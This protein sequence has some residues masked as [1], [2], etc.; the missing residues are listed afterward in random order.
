M[1]TTA[2]IRRA[3]RYPDGRFD[4]LT[5]GQ[6]R[7]RL[8]AVDT[9]LRALP[10]RPGALPGRADRPRQEAAAPGR[11]GRAALPR[12]PRAAPARSAT[13]DGPEIEIELEIE[14]DEDDD[15]TTRRRCDAVAGRSDDLDLAHGGTD[16]VSPSRPGAAGPTRLLLDRGH[17][18]AARRD[19][20]SGPV[21]GRASRAAPGGGATPHR[22]RRPDGPVLR[23]HGAHPGRPGRARRCSKR[24]TR[25]ARLRGLDRLLARESW[26][27]RQGLR[28]I[29][30]D[31]AQQQRRG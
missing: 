16:A 27:L 28:P 25:V 18:S 9:R 30:I 21:T 12:V 5:V 24:R 11:A 22:D 6:R 8:E 31:A 14:V 17:R 2:T 23:P 15:E 20:R 4:I 3:G 29:I 10:R 13:G 26:F 19:G 7:F 1:G